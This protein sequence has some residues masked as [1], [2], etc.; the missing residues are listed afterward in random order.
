MSKEHGHSHKAGGEPKPPGKGASQLVGQRVDSPNRGDRADVGRQ[1]NQLSDNSRK[2]GFTDYWMVLFT[3]GICLAA[4]ISA[5]IAHEQYVAMNGQLDAMKSQLAQQKSDAV[6]SERNFGRQ[7]NS[8]R[9][10][11]NAQIRSNTDNLNSQLR[12][13]DANVTRQLA[14]LEASLR[15]QN[16][17]A[18]ASEKSAGTAARALI[19]HEAEQRANVD[20]NGS[21]TYD[22]GQLHVSMQLHNIGPTAARQ[23]RMGFLLSPNTL[24]IA[25]KD[26]IKRQDESFKTLFKGGTNIGLSYLSPSESKTL[27]YPSVTIPQAVWDQMRS[28]RGGWIFVGRV[29]YDDIFGRSH[30]TNLCTFQAGGDQAQNCPFHNDQGDERSSGRIQP[31]MR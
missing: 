19:D 16:R 20:L 17:F 25:G 27:V 24:G 7:L 6:S 21:V 10:N 31:R 3:G 2:K 15:E 28:V 26:L 22:S 12:D 29:T 9:I 23:L 1:Q 18:S 30:W 14:A 5:V 4:V 13:E 8:N 11:L